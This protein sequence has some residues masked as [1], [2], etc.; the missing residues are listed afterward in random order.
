MYDICFSHSDF[1]HSC[2]TDSRFIHITT[3]DPISFLFMDAIP[4]YIHSTT[5]LSTPLWMHV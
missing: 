2:V 1:P 5:S 4:L 3:N